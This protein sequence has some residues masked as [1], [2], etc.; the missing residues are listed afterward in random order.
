M[1]FATLP[2]NLLVRFWAD[3]SWTNI[4]VLLWMPF[5]CQAWADHVQV[6]LI[7]NC[8]DMLTR[9]SWTTGTMLRAIIDGHLPG[10]TIFAPPPNILI[11]LVPK[12]FRR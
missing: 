2:P 4:A 7:C 10:V 12:V 6:P 1:P 9:A 3:I 8:D 5:T 11:R